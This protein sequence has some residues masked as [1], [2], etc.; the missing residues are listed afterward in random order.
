MADRVWSI[1]LPADLRF[2]QDKSAAYSIQKDKLLSKEQKKFLIEGAYNPKAA[3]DQ[4]LQRAFG[5]DC[6]ELLR[7]YKYDLA[8]FG[9]VLAYD[10]YERIKN[11]QVKLMKCSIAR[12]GIP[13]WS[14]KSSTITKMKSPT[15][16]L[17]ENEFLGVVESALSNEPNDFKSFTIR[18]ARGSFI[19][20]RRP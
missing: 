4:K 1:P 16:I 9:L 15:V 14:A 7:K 17:E 6:D 2:L 11:G 18:F 12:F 13:T 10:K 5:S 19:E 3:V 20:I 8:S